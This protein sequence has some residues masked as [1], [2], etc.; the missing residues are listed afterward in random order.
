MPRFA[1]PGKKCAARG[2]SRCDLGHRDRNGWQTIVVT[3]TCQVGTALKQAIDR[4]SFVIVA[5][6]S[7]SK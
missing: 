2:L 7:R 6:C 1:P 3:I 4:W 5:A